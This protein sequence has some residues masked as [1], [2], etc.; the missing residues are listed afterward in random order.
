M[1]I[2]RRDL[3]MALTA[4]LGNGFGYLSGIPFG[5]YVPLAVL[6]SAG[7]TYGASLELGRQRILGTILGGALLYVSFWGLKDIPMA[8]AIALTLGSLRLLGGLLKL[9][10]GYK[11]GG[12]IVVMGW[13][14]H[15]GHPYLDHHPAVL[16]GV[17]CDP[18][19]LSAA[20]V[21]A[22]AQWC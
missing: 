19:G 10:V 20:A 17:W 2:T 13:L 7:G 14:V 12:L 18:H 4:G 16:D 5:F 1:L 3:R 11:V 21:L 22:D 15:G 6:A 8:L 9:K